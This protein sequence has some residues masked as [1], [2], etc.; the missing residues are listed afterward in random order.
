M[1]LFEQICDQNIKKYGTESKRVLG[2]II[3]QYSDR[4]HFIYEILQNAED[5]GATRIKF[6]L[7]R[8]AFKLFHNGRPFT[9]D[10]IEGVCGIAK[11]TKED[12]TRIGH[13]G[14]GFKSVYCYTELPRI[15]S[16]KYHFLIRDQL[17]PEEIQGI[18]NL[19]TGE[20]CMILPF[21]KKNVPREVAFK[22]IR[23]A[24]KKKI[25]AESIM[26]L[27]NIRDIDISIEGDPEHILISKEK[28]DFDKDRNKGRV[29][30]LSLRTDIINR[31]TEKKSVRDG[32]YLFFTEND[33][34]AAAVVFKVE[35]KELTAIKH[36]HI[37]AYFPTA[38]EAHQ[39]F[40]I[41]APFDTTP[42]RDNFKEG[43][44]YG[45]H[46][47]RLVKKISSLITFAFLWMRDH[48]Y[49]TAAGLKTVFPIYEYSEDDVLY[50]IYQNSIEIIENEAILPTNGRQAFRNIR[51][52]YLPVSMGIVDIIDSEDLRHLLRERNI[53]WLA[54]EMSTDAY[55]DFREF[56]NNNF[57]LKTLEWK[58]LVPRMDARYLKEKPLSWMENLTS[59]IVGYC[60]RKGGSDRHYIDVSDVPLV[61]TTRGE[62]ICARGED[63]KLQVYLNNP[64]T[65]RYRIESTFL[66]N[67]SIRYFYQIALEIP[68]YNLQQ[69]ALEI[70][71]PKYKTRQPDFETDDEFSENVEDLKVIKEAIKQNSRVLESLRDKYI[72]TDG[73]GWY[74]A[75]ELYIR[76]N[77]SRSGFALVQ[78]ILSINYLYE[79]YFED[80]IACLKLDERFFLEIG[81]SNCLRVVNTSKKDYLSAVR[82]YIGPQAEMDLRSQIF[83]KTYISDKLKWDFNYEGFPEIFENM[84]AERSLAIA[85]FLNAHEMEFDIQG[86]I[87][88]A[89]DKYFSGKNVDSAVAYTMI[90]LQ[91]CF[92]KWIYTQNDQQPHSPL[93]VEK[94]DI[95]PQYKIA[96][97]LM[98][99]LPFKEVQT[100]LHEWI[101][102]NIENPN[103]RDIVKNLFK[104]PADQ[105]VK[106]A[107]ALAKL[108]AKDEKRRDGGRSI[109]DL[110]ADGNRG[111]VEKAKSDGGF[112]VVPISEPNKA[113]RQ[114]IL[115]AAFAESA[116]H[117]I[118]AVRGVFFTSRPCDSKEERLFLQSEY[119]GHCQICKKQIIKYNGAPYF[120]AVNILRFSQL[121]AKL[122]STDKY[123]WNSLCLCPNCAAQYKV[124]SKKMSD[125]YEQVM[126]KEIIPDSEESININIEFP[127]GE[128]K[129]IHYSP[130]HFMALQEA[131]KI[132]QDEEG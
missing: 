113:K 84:T 127:L 42:A 32:N 61:R 12:G 99:R 2:I 45:K 94:D 117:K 119:G 47:I 98:Q 125:L 97:R 108:Q 22:E 112:D 18:S 30:S 107:K 7:A 6:E 23:D 132:F 122:R 126:G 19:S 33:R 104:A 74:R 100:A 48:G 9:I 90:G 35:D 64:D 69:E 20:T 53:D 63:G 67:S 116:D 124:C 51:E 16:G 71:L 115:D 27:N 28:Y 80:N 57:D 130:R 70:I 37:Y 49:L 14:I 123:G 106:A 41:H 25:S 46:N 85:R 96:G 118:L 3:N 50:D 129:T 101:D 43:E 114:K 91:L 131:F 36:S 87:V 34:E 29:F 86:N 128:T 81:C 89:D 83:R 72:V 59:R 111:Q 88:G 54:R 120:E 38:K 73:Y 39:N 105:L 5:A 76:N 109:T 40:I 21:D 11:G 17:F 102:A 4:T 95:L 60:T 62:Q 77:E 8:D 52:V 93:E 65:A 92:K 68:E 82:K 103:E 24:L 78:G 26:M 66:D 15:Y 110:I 121:P 44:E 31:Q 79:R 1:T 58:D 55:S 56:L 75:D 10:D 13:F